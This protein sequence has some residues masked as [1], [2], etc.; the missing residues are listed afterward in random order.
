V[1]AMVSA[2]VFYLSTLI[3]LAIMLVLES[4]APH[5]R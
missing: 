2:P 3:I 5:A 4:S 1:L